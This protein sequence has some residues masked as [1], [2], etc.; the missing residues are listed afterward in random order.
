MAEFS[1]AK[2]SIGVG[3]ATDALE[4][5]IVAAGVGSGDEVIFCSHTMVA[6]ASAI[7]MSGAIPVPVDAGLDHLI[8]PLSIERA[9]TSKTK[10][11]LPTH[12]NG[13]TCNMDAILE[14]ANKHDLLI[15]EDSAQALGS[16][17]KGRHAGTFGVGGCISFYPAKIW[18]AW[19]TVALSCAMIMRY[20]K[21]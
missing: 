5:L 19:V 2:Y 10:A 16:R 13:R 18:A 15:F 9:I 14:I 12:L 7:H 11:I 8:D 6:T 21:K 1:G 4:L 17:Y 20:T 3:N